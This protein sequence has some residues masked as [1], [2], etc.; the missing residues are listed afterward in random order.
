MI[1]VPRRLKFS[2]PDKF[3]PKPDRASELLIRRMERPKRGV[4]RVKYDKTPVYRKGRVY[5]P[6]PTISLPN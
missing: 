2:V 5:P 3:G 1:A 6:R 4:L